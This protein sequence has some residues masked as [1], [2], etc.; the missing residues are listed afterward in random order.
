[1]KKQFNQTLLT[2]LVKA[3]EVSRAVSMLM[4]RE[5]YIIIKHYGLDG[6][7]PVSLSAL[8]RDYEISRERARQIETAALNRVLFMLKKK[9]LCITVRSNK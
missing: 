7:D 5:R 2:E 3:G 9:E 4:P 6:S 8:A 1:M